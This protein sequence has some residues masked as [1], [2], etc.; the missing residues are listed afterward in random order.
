[1]KL[2]QVIQKPRKSGVQ[3]DDNITLIRACYSHLFHILAFF[4]HADKAAVTSYVGS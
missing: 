2:L 1:M 4:V 3:Q